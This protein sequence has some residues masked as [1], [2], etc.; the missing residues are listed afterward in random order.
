MLRFVNGEGDKI[1][2]MDRSLESGVAAA[3][4]FSSVS[5]LLTHPPQS[6]VQ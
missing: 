2:V 6:P 4:Q 1:E 5:V 3:L